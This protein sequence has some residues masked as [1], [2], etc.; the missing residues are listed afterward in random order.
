MHKTK[1]VSCDVFCQLELLF[2]KERNT[3]TSDK[4][5]GWESRYHCERKK[6]KKLSSKRLSAIALNRIVQTTIKA[7]LRLRCVSV[8]PISCTTRCAKQKMSSTSRQFSCMKD[9]CVL[10]FKNKNV[11]QQP[12]LF[13]LRQCCKLWDRL[14]VGFARLFSD[15]NSLPKFYLFF[16]KLVQPKKTWYLDTKSALQPLTSVEDHIHWGVT[17]L[18][19]WSCTHWRQHLRGG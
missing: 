5:W 2:L 13:D 16:H 6:K 8:K 18:G 11:T 1:T 9:K 12:L 7:I 4:A 3:R 10:K 15:A 17:L 19:G 14:L